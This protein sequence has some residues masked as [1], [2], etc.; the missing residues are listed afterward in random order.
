MSPADNELTIGPMVYVKNYVVH[1]QDSA[2]AFRN[3]L[4]WENDI[5]GHA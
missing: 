3:S 5:I 4:V 1:R 2:D